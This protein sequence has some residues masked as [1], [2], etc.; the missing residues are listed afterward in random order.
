MESA[1]GAVTA[2]PA[3]QS[4]SNQLIAAVGASPGPRAPQPQHFVLNLHSLLSRSERARGSALG[5]AHI[6]V[7]LSS[8]QP[9]MKQGGLS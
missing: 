6:R 4:S 2:S 8:P 9:Q 3:R 1:Q 7:P 5:S